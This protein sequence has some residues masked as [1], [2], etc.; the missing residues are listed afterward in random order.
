MSIPLFFSVLL[1]KSLYQLFSLL[2]KSH[3]FDYFLI[4]IS[5][6]VIK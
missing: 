3:L 4:D 6:F 1:F 2:D 5:K